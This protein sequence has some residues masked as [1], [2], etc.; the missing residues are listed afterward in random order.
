MFTCQAW[1]YGDEQALDF[2][3][4]TVQQ[5]RSNIRLYMSVVHGAMRLGKNVPDVELVVDGKI[6]EGFLRQMLL[7]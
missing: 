4:L 2:M 7:K 1:G 6:K 3:E 5:G